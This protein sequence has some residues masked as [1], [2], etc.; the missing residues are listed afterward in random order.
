MKATA[1][2]VGAAAFLA[3]LG[4]AASGRISIVSEDQAATAWTLAPDAPRVVA[5]YPVTVADKSQEVCVNIGYLID[6]DGKTSQFT[7][8]KAWSS[9]N[10]DRAPDQAALQPFVQSAAAAVSMWRFVPVDGK[11]RQIYTSATFGFAV[12]SGA[13]TDAI[14]ERCRISDLAGFIA[15]AKAK[16]DRRGDLSTARA[17]MRTDREQ[18]SPMGTNF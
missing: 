18:V 13:A 10:P 1:I 6:K 14:R 12:A 4:A 2:V 9:A 3:A 17:R 8:M 11:P 15:E 7:Q 16:A 5:G